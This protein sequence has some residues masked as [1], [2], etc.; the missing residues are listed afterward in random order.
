MKSKKIEFLCKETWIDPPRPAKDLVPEWYKRSEKFRGGKMQLSEEKVRQ[1]INKDLKLCV[2]FLDSLL[3]G[4]IFCLWQDLLVSSDESGSTSFDWE[5]GTYLMDERPLESNK[6]LPRPAG[7]Y[8]NNFIWE[9]PL[10]MRLPKGYSAIITHPFN[11]FDLPFT[12]VTAI[13]DADSMM[14]CGSVPFFM[15]EDFRGVVKSGTP[16]F[17]IIPFKRES[18][19]SEISEALFD[20]NDHLSHKYRSVFQGYYRDFLWHK[21]KFE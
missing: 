20:L 21:K 10:M 2:P 3:T 1:V 12:T 6:Y 16:I 14:T 7:H 17:Q 15:R 5:M 11:R 4:Y 19:K 9:S 8:D 18:W 13:V